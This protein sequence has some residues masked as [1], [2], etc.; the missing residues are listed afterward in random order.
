MNPA[1]APKREDDDWIRYIATLD[2]KLQVYSPKYTF[3][4][5]YFFTNC[6]L[7]FFPAVDEYLN[8]PE[9]G[10]LSIVIC[11]GR[12]FGRVL[13]LNVALLFILAS[14]KTL[15]FLRNTVVGTI[16]PIDEAMP[17]LHSFIAYACFAAATIHGVCHCIA[18][19]GMN[20]WAPGFGKNTWC[21]V[22]GYVIFSLYGLIV[23]TS[24]AYMRRRRFEVFL[25]VH[26]FG[27]L[28]FIPIICLHGFYNAKPYSY[29]WVLGPA[30]LYLFDKLARKMSE[31]QASVRIHVDSNQRKVTCSGGIGTRHAGGRN[32]FSFLHCQKHFY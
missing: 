29:K 21:I 30:M 19:T 9:H 15:G 4:L 10:F 22:S 2:A 11:V 24:M 18:S 27:S 8:W 28:L 7:F 1:S 13:N 6:V 32:S 14:R 17:E 3:L 26:M 16:L 5:S 25:H 31:N 12:G 23:A 20:L